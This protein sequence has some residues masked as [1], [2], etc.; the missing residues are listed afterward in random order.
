[1]Q[2]NRPVK[3]GRDSRSIRN[4]VSYEIDFTSDCI[5]AFTQEGVNTG[6]PEPLQI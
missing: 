2:L 1:M 4:L 5:S 3:D 6:N